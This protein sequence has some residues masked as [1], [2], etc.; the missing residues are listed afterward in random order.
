MGFGVKVH[1]SHIHVINMAETG[2]GAAEVVRKTLSHFEEE[3]ESGLDL[4]CDVIP[5][6]SCADFTQTSIGYFLKSLLMMKAREAPLQRSGGICNS[7]GNFT[8]GLKTE[9]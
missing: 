6:Q 5:G 9:N 2:E 1:I 4:T 7:A 3:G 8:V